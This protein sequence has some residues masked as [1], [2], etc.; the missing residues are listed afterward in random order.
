MVLS[1]ASAFQLTS[2][3]ITIQDQSD[4]AKEVAQVENRVRTAANLRKFTIEYN[5]TIIGNPYGDVSVDSN[6]TAIQ[7]EFRDLFVNA[8]YVVGRTDQG[9]WLISWD[10]QG[11][12][13]VVSVYSVRTTVTPGAVSAQT[14]TL[15]N[16]YFLGSTPAATSKVVLVNDLDETTFGATSSVFYEYVIL[17]HQQDPTENRSSTVQSILNSSGLGYNNTNTEVF[18][19]V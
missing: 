10:Q 4:L 17:V 8:G 7:I 12:E 2:A 15:L 9:F 18:K 13:Q 5:A 11:P 19:L 6:L 16:N 14:I 3:A 1:S